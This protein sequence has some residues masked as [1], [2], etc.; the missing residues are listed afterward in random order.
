MHRPLLRRFIFLFAF[1]LLLSALL[2]I[3][4]SPSTLEIISASVTILGT[5]FALIAYFFP[6]PPPYI[7]IAGERKQALRGEWIGTAAQRD[8]PYTHNVTATINAST[9]IVTGESKLTITNVMPHQLLGRLTFRGGFAH[10]RFLK[11]EYQFEDKPGLVQFG[12]LILELSPD[13]QHLDGRFIGYGA[14][15]QHLVWGEVHLQKLP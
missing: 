1:F 9:H 5:I 8:A 4:L 10:D 15:S 13:A 12:A 3:F 6:L 2:L 7:H 11:L 14:T